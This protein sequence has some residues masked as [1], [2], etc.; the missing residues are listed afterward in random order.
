MGNDEIGTRAEIND[1]LDEVVAPLLA[2]HHGRLFKTVGD[3][4]LAEFASVVEAVDCA[5]QIQSQMVQR[6]G[7]AGMQ[8]RIGINLG[9]VIVEGDDLHGDGVNVAARLEALAEPGGVCISRSARDQIRDKLSYGMA[10]MGEIEVKNIARPVRAFRVLPAGEAPSPTAAS[11]PR[12][13]RFGLA[14]AL[15][16]CAVIAAGLVAWLEPWAG[17]VEAASLE[18]MQL[19][20]PDRPSVA[21]L[22]FAIPQGSADDQLFADA[23]TEDLTRSLARVSGLFVIARSSTLDFVGDKASPARAAEQLGVRHVVRATLR[24]NGDQLR[25][26]AELIDALSGRIVWSDRLEK[27]SGDLFGLQDQLVSALAS[28]LSSDLRRVQDQPRYTASPEAFMLWTR[29]DHE[30]WQNTE[31][32][33]AA[34]RTFARQALAIDPDFAR[35][36]AVLAFVETQSGYFRVADDPQDALL[37]G[38]ELAERAVALQPADWYP[39]SVLAQALMNLRRYDEAYAAY[40]AAL[41]L[42]PA[43]ARLLTRSALPL[44]FMGRGA[45]A[46]ERLRVAMRLNPFYDWLPDQLLGQSLYLQERYQ[47]AEASLEKARGKNPRFIGNLWWRAATLAQLGDIEQARMV[48]SQIQE[49]MPQARIST[50][51]IQI[52]DASAMARFEDGLRRAGLPD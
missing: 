26:D 2:T 28:R 29:A 43:H 6:P 13:S 42:E 22:P 45:E 39:K 51:F 36:K 44:I 38:L 17:R 14:A 18:E 32:S 8:L 5:M 21:V 41:A 25:V 27:Q 46:E 4:F 7:T 31:P 30:S 1:L 16:L 23:V 9:D 52:S 10:D 33:Y 35:G 12:R 50:S 11:G 24:R 49:R 37:R 20:L 48:V 15:G 40:D 34:A 3:G 19:P 47:E